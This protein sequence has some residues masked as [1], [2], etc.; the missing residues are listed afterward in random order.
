MYGQPAPGSPLD[1]SWVDEQLAAAAT[2]WV[3][4]HGGDHPHP[5]PV[6]GVWCDEVLHLSIG[7]VV[8]SKLLDHHRNV[9]VHL[10]SGVDVV[11]VE[12]AVVGF[13]GEAGV[14]SAYN[15]KYTW[16][17]TIA[18]YGLLT[19]IFPRKVLAWRSAGWAGRDGFQQ[20]GRWRFSARS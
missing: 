5:R 15:D 10:D 20:A 6:W 17:Y 19:S 4:A 12:G 14:I 2:F 18:E 7:S 16:D 8:V 9:T 11:I 13:S 1:W 3:A